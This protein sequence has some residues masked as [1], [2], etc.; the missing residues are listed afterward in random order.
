MSFE[1]LSFEFLS[2][3]RGMKCCFRKLLVVDMNFFGSGVL[4]TGFQLLE[5]GED[6]NL[7][8]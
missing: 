1:F 8:R 3:I 5:L 6:S 4:L 2:G 7:L